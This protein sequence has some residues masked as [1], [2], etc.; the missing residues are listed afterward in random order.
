MARPVLS[1]LLL[2]LALSLLAFGVRAS[3]LSVEVAVCQ[4]S[5]LDAR[6]AELSVRAELEADGVVRVANGAEGV[7]GDGQLSTTVGCDGSLTTLLVL[8]AYRTRREHRSSLV[9]S[10]ADPSARSRVLALAAA[11][12][13]RA[14]WPQLT[15]PEAQEAPPTSAASAAAAAPTIA[16]LPRKEEIAAAPLQPLLPTSEATP[17]APSPP[18]TS[19][20]AVAADARLRWFVDYASVAVGA[21]AGA[22]FGALRLR[23]EGLVTSRD[24]ALGSASLGSGAGCVGYRV[25]QR[26][27]GPFTIA[28]YPML[29]VGLT[30]MRGD[31]ARPAV[32]VQPV[33]GFY[34]DLRLLGE[35]HLRSSALSPTLSAEL[36]RATGFVARSA[37]RVLGASGGFFVGAS[38]G[39]RY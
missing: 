27:L 8:K 16:I 4:G 25:L 9:L 24:D 32:R 33:T 1:A 18:R 30:W 22:D 26:E 34:G 7:E 29:A 38:L 15:E 11:E 2:S 19:A 37:D 14:E 31:S 36:G 12:L 6:E 39:A 17:S 28:G 21:S 35:L 3:T 13:V 10:D 20:W 23:A 5:P